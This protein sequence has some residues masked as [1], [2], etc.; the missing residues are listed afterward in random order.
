MSINGNKM[1][2]YE[3]MTVREQQ[4]HLRTIFKDFD[5]DDANVIQFSTVEVEDSDED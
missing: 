2:D 1:P 5:E 3:D 4:E